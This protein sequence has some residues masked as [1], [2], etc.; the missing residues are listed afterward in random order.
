MKL[1]DRDSLPSALK[2]LNNRTIAFC[3]A[4]L[5]IALALAGCGGGDPEPDGRKDDPSPN[6][7][8]R[9]EACK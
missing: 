7:A 4:C 5:L 9:Q 1:L 2:P 8:M 3:A 6:C